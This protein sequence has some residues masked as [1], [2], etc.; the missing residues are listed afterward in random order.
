MP[1]QEATD[2]AV[3]YQLISPQTNFLLVHERAG[4][5][6]AEDMPEL[7]SIRQMLPA[8]WGGAGSVMSASEPTLKLVQKCAGRI[9][10]GE[11]TDIRMSLRQPS[12][13]QKSALNEPLEYLDIPAFLRRQRDPEPSVSDQL[14]D[15]LKA[16][17]SGV[18]D[19]KGE[20]TGPLTPQGL[21]TYLD[22]IP[23]S[24]WPQS[25][26]E[27]RDLGLPQELVDWLEDIFASEYPMPLAE[28]IVV[29][30]F[31]AALM[32]PAIY[33]RLRKSDGPLKRLQKTLRKTLG[34]SESS[35]ETTYVQPYDDLVAYMQSI[36]PDMWPEVMKAHVVDINN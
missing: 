17:V 35:P 11:M 31:L 4:D 12:V 27:L 28:P 26:A 15:D 30:V 14:I 25:Y 22:S 33:S 23:Q 36:E 7:H 21:L 2:L 19:A 13:A 24:T 10:Y 5:E 20:E 32:S 34:K 6:K 8:G 18:F 1:S 16:R 9:D 29:E 3:A